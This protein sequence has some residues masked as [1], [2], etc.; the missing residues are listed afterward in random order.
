MKRIRSMIVLLLA[1]LL[2]VGCMPS[3]AALDTVPPSEYGPAADPDYADDLF[4]TS[5]VHAID[6]RISEEDWSDLLEHPTDKTKYEVTVVIDG[7]TAEDASFSTKGHSS[8]FFVADDEDSQRYSFKIN[9]ENGA[10][11][12]T[13]HGL[14]K[15]NLNNM[16]SDATY[17]KDFLSYGLFGKMG[18]AAPRASYVWL[19]INGEA[20]GLYVAVEE[21]DRSFLGRAFGGEGTLYQ[22]EHEELAAEDIQDIK[23]GAAA[24]KEG[25]AG[26]DLAYSDDLPEHYPDIFDCAVTEDDAETQARVVRA[27]KGLS[28]R[29]DLASYLDTEAV[30][31]YFA[32]HN[33]LVNFDS[34]TGPMLHNYYLYEHGGRLSVVP[35]DYNLIFGT[36]PAD[37]L[38]DSRS[39]STLIVNQGIDS[40]LS[41]SPAT[42]QERPMWSWIMEDESY[43]ASYH[44]A[45]GELISEHFDSGEF[46]EEFDAL[47]AMLLPYVEQDPTA[48][49]TPEEFTA[50]YETLREVSLLRAESIR[51]QL[52]GELSTV[53]ERQSKGDRVDA[54]G[55]IIADMGIPLD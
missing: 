19:T 39:D 40:P 6:V 49:Y 26:A 30:I 51:R 3:A 21:V 46:A 47:Y 48:F 54:S 22:P 4:D 31:R 38:M 2:T 53:T 42:E 45:L 28:E 13:W 50:A 7:E 35:W 14:R 25:A 5:F 23:A 36:F 18:V 55:F 17:M 37:G 41:G 11:G 1:G 9:F 12:R 27:L 32:V 16:F 44:D 15:L 10:E 52:D 43:R 8:L 33:Y 29:E 20:Q 24:Q 34:Y